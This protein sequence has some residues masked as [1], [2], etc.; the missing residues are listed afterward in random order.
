MGVRV[1]GDITGCTDTSTTTVAQSCV[2]A[3]LQQG[4][5]A[6]PCDGSQA[7]AVDRAFDPQAIRD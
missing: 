6:G 3:T 5:Q 1:V 2:V 7:E 4:P